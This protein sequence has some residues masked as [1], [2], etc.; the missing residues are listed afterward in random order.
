MDSVVAP[1]AAAAASETLRDIEE[2]L[3]R[4][5]KYSCE[6]KE[7]RQRRQEMQVRL[8][9]EVRG[10]HAR[11]DVGHRSGPKVCSQEVFP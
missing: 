4:V 2:N 3:E 6:L 5:G 10:W 7:L 11:G 1:Q 8:G 9:R